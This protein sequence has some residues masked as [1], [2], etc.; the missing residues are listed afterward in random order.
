[1]RWALLGK[2]NPKEMLF[3]LFW[4]WKI[5]ASLSTG[6][7]SI[8][9]YQIIDDNGEKETRY[10]N[11]ILEKNIRGRLDGIQSSRESTSLSASLSLYL[12]QFVL[13]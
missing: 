2:R 4:M 13:K 12:P 9:R 1:M 8:N 7:S 10:W 6:K 5:I 11:N 3:P